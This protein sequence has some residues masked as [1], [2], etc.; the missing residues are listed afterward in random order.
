MKDLRKT[1]AL[2]QRTRTQNNE[3][4]PQGAPWWPNL[5]LIAQ[6]RRFRSTGSTFI[7][8][9]YTI[10]I[11]TFHGLILLYFH[12]LDVDWTRHRCP[13]LGHSGIPCMLDLPLFTVSI[14]LVPRACS[15]S[16]T[17]LSSPGFPQQTISLPFLTF[18]RALAGYL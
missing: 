1:A 17:S 2:T 6:T 16:S 3:F 5:L 18:S 12:S 9:L 15:S 7:Y 11:Y 14:N 8:I 10:Y 13:P 4:Q